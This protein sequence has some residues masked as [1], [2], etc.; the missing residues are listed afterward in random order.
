VLT[1]PVRLDR[2]LRAVWSGMTSALAAGNKAVAMQYLNGQAQL[3]YSPVFD[4]LLPQMPTIVLAFSL[5][6]T[7]AISDKFGEYAVNQ[8]IDGVNRLHFIHYLL[9]ADGVWR[10]DSK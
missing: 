5:P 9:D 6:K 3:K 2:N 4:A 8:I 7:G 1:D 10:V